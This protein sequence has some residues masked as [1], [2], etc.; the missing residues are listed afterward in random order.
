MESSN[1]EVLRHDA[2][3]YSFEGKD[4]NMKNGKLQ[5]GLIGIGGI[6]NQKHMPSLSQMKDLC[7]LVAFCDIIKERAEAGAKEFGA[8]GA[9][10]YTDYKELLADDSIDVVHVLTPNVAHAQ[11]VVDAFAAGKHVLCEKPM[12]HSSSEAQ[13]MIDA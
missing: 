3:Q 13:R 1:S 11:I 9:K 4:S 6:A 12:S 8:P 7:E 10:V 5:I 2:Q